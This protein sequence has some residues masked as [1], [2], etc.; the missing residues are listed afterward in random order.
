MASGAAIHSARPS[1]LEHT[2]PAEQRHYARRGGLRGGPARGRSSIRD[3][4]RSVCLADSRS[5][6]AM[7]VDRC[8]RRSVRVL[9]ILVL[10][11]FD[12]FVSGLLADGPVPMSAAVI[13]GVIIA[14]MHWYASM[15]GW[16]G[17]PIATPRVLLVRNVFVEHR[18]PWGCIKGVGLDRGLAI[19][20]IDENGAERRVGS[21][22]FGGSVIGDLTGYATFRRVV[23]WIE[24]RKESFR[25]EGAPDDSYVRSVRIPWISVVVILIYCEI[26]TCLFASV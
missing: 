9:L 22:L 15:F 7:K 13:V 14:L 12:L 18:M 8:G 21:L 17:R 1:A 6:C 11:V 10:A 25:A 2:V 19:S 26:G 23:A 3:D 16:G 24:E 20:V 4:W 5:G